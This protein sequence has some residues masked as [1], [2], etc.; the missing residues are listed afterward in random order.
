LVSLSQTR[1]LLTDGMSSTC[2][3]G[4]TTANENG[5]GCQC[6]RRRWSS[7]LVEPKSPRMS[8]ILDAL[9]NNRLSPSLRREPREGD[10]RDLCILTSHGRRRL[11][12]KSCT[13]GAADWMYTVL[14]HCLCFAA[15]TV[16][17]VKAHTP[18]R[19][20]HGRSSSVSRERKVRS[21][22][23]LALGHL[24]AKIPQLQAAL[25]G[26]VREHHRFLLQSLLRQLHFL[27]AEIAALD[28]RL[29]Q[30]GQ[31]H[32]ELADVLNRWITVPGV[33]RW[34]LGA[35]SQRFE[36]ML[37]SFPLQPIWPAGRSV[38]GKQREC[39]Q[40]DQQQDS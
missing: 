8:L 9:E 10:F 26:R 28:A 35:L 24:R 32:M 37:V 33:D 39:R 31:E 15:A 38:S 14:H 23:D 12:W 22:A 34:Q 16:Q 25:A 7:A 3:F 36:Q 29:D 20:H 21:R 18:L 5:L 40:A 13:R 2:L 6:R 30:L 1:L 19:M 27:E 17:T 4:G 11:L